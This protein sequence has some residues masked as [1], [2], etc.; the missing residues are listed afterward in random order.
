MTMASSDLFFNID[1]GYL[2]GLVRGF[3]SGLLREF[4][5]TNLTQCETIEDLKLHL[6][7]TNY[8]NFLQNEPS[9]IAVS[10]LD[11]RLRE[12]L[13]IEFTHM[14]NHSFQPLTK[15]MDYITYNYMI[16][17]IILLISGT[18]HARS[19]DELMP[20]CH[21]LGSFEELP[22]IAMVTNTADLYNAVL[23]DSPLGP[24]FKDCLSEQ[25]LDEMNIEV[26]RNTLHK[27]Y[28]ESFYD[29][30]QRIGGSTAETMGKILQFEADR[31][32]FMITINSFGTELSKDDRKNLYPKCGHLYPEGLAKLSEAEDQEQVRQVAAYYSDYRKI[33]DGVGGPD[34]KTLEDRFFEFEVELHKLSFMQQFHFG[35]F[36]SFVRMKEQ[37]QRNIVWIA[38]CISQQHRAKIHN[39]I[40]II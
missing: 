31:R 17:N 16:D 37:E 12:R 11:E 24:Y 25:D 28:L 13:I 19:L 5:Y 32:A 18:L 15:F 7:G 3:K 4:D 14:Q 20:K 22:T 8:G 33:F 1:H 38:E 40:P 6:Q 35:V 36:Y 34:G 9:P 23:V 29:F 39:Y 26:I 10:T 27:A 30:C 2:E 21:P